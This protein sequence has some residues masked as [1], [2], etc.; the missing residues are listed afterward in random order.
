MSELM[1]GAHRL[2]VQVYEDGLWSDE[3][4][5]YHTVPVP[6]TPS[7]GD[8]TPLITPDSDGETFSIWVVFAIVFGGVV[9]LIGL[10]MIITLSKDEMEEMLGTSSH[11]RVEPDEF[12]DLESELAEFD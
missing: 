5:Y 3:K 2:E 12:Q 7:S 4:I 9:A 10:Y 1:P 8:D 11:S 6:D